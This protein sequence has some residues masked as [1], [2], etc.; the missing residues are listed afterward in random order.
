MTAF[1]ARQ[2]G[3][4]PT[5]VVGLDAF[6]TNLVYEVD[7][8]ELRLIVKAS[9]LR[10]ALRAE[11]W[12]CARGAAAGCAAPDLLGF[13]RL[14]TEDPMS[15]FIMQ[16]LPGR[17]IAA[18]HSAFREVGVCLRRLHDSKTPGFGSLAEGSWRE[19]GEPSLQHST[20]LGFL[21]AICAEGGALAPDG[22]TAEIEARAGALAAVA[23]GS[24]CHGDLKYAHIL[25]DGDRLSG[26]IDWG[27]ALFAD[28]L[29]DIARFAH[30]ADPVSLAVLLEGYDPKGALADELAWRLPLYSALWN[31]VDAIVDRRLAV[32]NA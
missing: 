28:P 5:R 11:A 16:R 20:W 3:R 27:D 6:A 21:R 1:V 15:A 25:V 26:V 8:G 14:D 2:L 23:E 7:A 13:G 12:A 17:P 31:L 29:F 18:G 22:L 30:R 19:D 9:S 32:G 24:L 4:A 10:D